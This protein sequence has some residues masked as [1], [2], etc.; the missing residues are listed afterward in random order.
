M[1]KYLLIFGFLVVGILFANPYTKAAPPKTIAILP[2]TN[3]EG[4]EEYRPLEEGL[5]QLLIADLSKA[6][7]IIVVEREELDKVL[8][9]MELSLSGLVQG[10]ELVS[11][12]ARVEVKAIDRETEE[13]LAV[14]RGS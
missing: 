6:K 10:E 14:N 8:E 7:D 3:P 13:I 11:C 1:S 5:T 9:E 12:K 4:I 2:F